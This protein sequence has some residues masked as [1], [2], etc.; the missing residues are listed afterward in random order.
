[1]QNFKKGMS[2]N[3][4]VFIMQ[5]LSLPMNRDFAIRG[6]ASHK[7]GSLN[8]NLSR[9]STP[10]LV[11]RSVPSLVNSASLTSDLGKGRSGS[12]GSNGGD[13]K[14]MMMMTKYRREPSESTL[15]EYAFDNP[16]LVPSP[17]HNIHM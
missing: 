13:N 9:D 5:I 16:G 7:S 1:M 10:D 17:T 14:S 15:P 6:P 12:L 3:S 8:N 11:S 4:I 2:S